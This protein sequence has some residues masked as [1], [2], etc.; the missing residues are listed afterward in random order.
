MYTIKV[1]PIYQSVQ[2]CI[3]WWGSEV[4]FNEV[5]KDLELKGF[6]L[7][8]TIRLSNK[9]IR[10]AWFPKH[11][12]GLTW[13]DLESTIKGTIQRMEAPVRTVSQA[14]LQTWISDFHKWVKTLSS[15]KERTGLPPLFEIDQLIARGDCVKADELLEQS[16]LFETDQRRVTDII[17]S[18]MFLKH[19]QKQHQRV[20]ELYL[21]WVERK[22][23]SPDPLMSYWIAKGA[24]SV[25]DYTQAYALLKELRNHSLESFSGDDRLD[26][27]LSLVE[28]HNRF[29]EYVE[30]LLL[31]GY[32]YNKKELT[33]KQKDLL[34]EESLK[35]VEKMIGVDQW[36]E[37]YLEEL[38]KDLRIVLIEEFEKEFLKFKIEDKSRQPEATVNPN[39]DV[40]E[41]LQHWEMEYRQNACSVI[42]WLQ[43]Y[44]NYPRLR[45]AL[46]RTYAESLKD[47]KKAAEILK[48]LD[49]D[50]LG[51]DD[52]LAYARIHFFYAYY[53]GQEED[54]LFWGE[55]C[56]KLQ[57]QPD[58]Q[59]CAAYGKLLCNKDEEKAHI[60]LKTAVEQGLRTAEIY[61]E[62]GS[63]LM[64]QGNYEGASKHFLEALRLNPGYE[65]S[66]VWLFEVEFNEKIKLTAA[67]GYLRSLDHGEWKTEYEEKY[68]IRL[69]LARKVDDTEKKDRLFEAYQDILEYLI[70]PKIMN[71]VFVREL[72]E[73]AMKELPD[74]ETFLDL[75]S[76]M[77]IVNR[78]ECDE[79]LVEM[80]INLAYECMRSETELLHVP[81]LIKRLVFLGENE[82]A[83]DI[84]L[85]LRSIIQSLEYKL[86]GGEEESE[87]RLDL[88]HLKVAIVSG[89]EHVRKRI[90]EKLEGQFAIVKVNEV[91]PAFEARYDVGMVTEKI[92]N[93]DVILYIYRCSKH[94]DAYTLD[95]AM[96]SV[97]D[98]PRLYV[99]GK[100]HSSALAIFEKYIIEQGYTG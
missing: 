34:E 37:A 45:V 76:S 50:S 68:R 46:A 98:I 93:V 65:D 78:R 24:L 6:D 18:Q 62:L 90:R 99:K 10:Y 96:D 28:L 23:E 16:R 39:L 31:S 77:E 25:K 40:D 51:D 74:T 89:Y 42:Y 32:L 82:L 15:P 14:N 4:L 7:K 56:V 12:H 47:Y 38:P 48:E 2:R 22:N 27:Q 84:R 60:Y 80:N 53:Q 94:S 20:W 59:V 8:K 3:E 44:V 19:R 86:P 49:Y 41:L 69:D 52:R 67:E 30:A 100:G 36:K 57:K 88:S 85:Q 95:S 75:L 79:L 1:P 73:Q 5:C 83:Q 63:L 72:L 71:V 11:Q 17:R 66:L 81:R 29:E 9:I 97:G 58:P 13:T 35:A 64:M 54:G 43:E 70:K 61:H 91:P 26:I 87:L 92:R 55:A 33:R 21:E